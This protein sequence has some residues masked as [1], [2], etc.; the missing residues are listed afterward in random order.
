M[1]EGLKPDESPLLGDRHCHEQPPPGTAS[2]LQ[3]IGNIIVS[4][5]GTGI[6]GLPFALRVAGWLAGSFAIIVAGIST[7]Y[8][9]IL[10][11]Q[12]RDKM[13]TEEPTTETR[14]YGDLGQKALGKTGRYLTESLILVSQCGGAVAYLLFIGQNL[15]SVFK[16][17]GFTTST[18]IFMLVP[19]EIALSWIGSLSALAP[20][21]IFAD[22]CNLLAMAIVV[23]EDVQKVFGGEFKFSDRQAISPGPGGL[24]FALGM[25]VFCFEGFGM[26]LALEQSMK[27]R[28]K[29]RGVLANAVAGIA[30]LYIVFGFFGYMAYGDATRDII[31]LNLTQNWSNIAVQIGMCMGLVFTFPIMVHPI[32]EIVEGKLRNARWFQKTDNDDDDHRGGYL[33]RWIGRS[34]MYLFRAVLIAALAFLASFVPGFGA[35]SSIVGSSVCAC[36]SFVLPALFH[37]RLLG[38]SLPRWRKVLDCFIMV[39][40]FAFAVYGTIST[41]MGV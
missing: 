33:A 17:N 10:L 31:T 7:Y 5:V 9:M 24:P 16:F 19:I 37:L 25:A 36:I 30:S 13:A 28:G 27:E 20:F 6:L 23:K 1:E 14:T 2:T 38:P 21:S 39:C 4:I 41:I 32:N 3:T 11:V 35:F 26:T 34:G 18:F 22:V 29:F 12:C 40:G 15:S 8:C